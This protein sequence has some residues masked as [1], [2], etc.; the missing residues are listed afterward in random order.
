MLRFTKYIEKVLNH[1]KKRTVRKKRKCHCGASIKNY[2]AMAGI[3][4]FK[5]DKC[6][7]QIK[8][9]DTLQVYV[10]FKVGEATVTNVEKF[11]FETFT[12]EDARLDGFK[13]FKD[14]AKGIHE[15]HEE[16]DIYSEEFHIIDFDPHWTPKVYGEPITIMGAG[17]SAADDM[18]RVRMSEKDYS[19]LRKQQ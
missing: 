16:N 10:L 11:D 17:M 2:G 1:T 19:I 13:D 4:P 5:R 14:F 15:L 12:D 9:G 7:C 6:I 8:K 3:A 18:V